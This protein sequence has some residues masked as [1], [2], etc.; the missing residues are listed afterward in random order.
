M[1][2]GEEYIS[3]EDLARQLKVEDAFVQAKKK[4]AAVNTEKEKLKGI[5]DKY[6]ALHSFTKTV[7]AEAKKN[8]RTA[9]QQL[10]LSADIVTILEKIKTELR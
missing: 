9:E 7:R 8:N 1:K 2:P 6:I 3:S 5:I 10:D 4:T